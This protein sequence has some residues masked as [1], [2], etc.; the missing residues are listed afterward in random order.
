MAKIDNMMTILWML[1]SGRKITAQQI[2]EKLEMNIR[3]VYRYIDALSASGVPI[4]AD[5]GHNGGYTLLHNFIESP[6]LFEV[7]EQTALLHAAAFAQEAGYYLGEALDSATSKL[8]M[9]A[10]QQQERLIQQHLQGLTVLSP[11]AKS[12]VE[13]VLK[14]LEQAI[15]HESSVDIEYQ[16]S[17]E[18]Q[19]TRRIVDPY[20]L[21]YWNNNWYVIAFCHLRNELRSFKVERIISINQTAI[22]FQRPTF[23]SAGEFFMKSLLPAVADKKGLMPLVVDG[24]ASALDSLCQHWF[25]GHHIKERTANKVIFLLEEE[26]IHTYVPYLLL[27]YGKSIQVL[28]P[29]SLKQTIIEVLHDLVHYYQV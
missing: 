29:S 25:L 24:K 1:H 26:S 9:Y 22:T 10:T 13:P 28:E 8:K 11:M 20:G 17:H 14:K 21:V 4:I 18:E 2:A 7:E 19:A 16:T 5:S 15:V 6:L 3:T 27:P 23:F 12:T